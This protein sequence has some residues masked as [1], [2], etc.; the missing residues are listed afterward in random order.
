M[1]INRGWIAAILLGISCFLLPAAR[2]D[3]ASDKP[4]PLTLTRQGDFLISPIITETQSFNTTILE[5]GA[6]FEGLEVNTDPGNEAVWRTEGVD[7]DGFGADALIFHAP[8]TRIQFKKRAAPEEKILTGKLWL[9]PYLAEEFER[10]KERARLENL[11]AGPAVALT[12]AGPAY[13]VIK[14]EEWGADESLRFWTPS[15]DDIQKSGQDEKAED[16][17][18]DFTTKY[19]DEIGVKLQIGIDPV[20]NLLRWPLSYSKT[21]RKI[22]VHHTDSDLHDLNGDLQMDSRDMKAYVRAIYRF[23]AITKGWGDIGYNYLIDPFG[24]IYEG[25]AGGE[26]VIG[27]HVLCHNNGTIGIAIIGNYQENEVPQPALDALT[28]LVA[29]KA[30]LY[31]LD[32]EAISSFR[33]KALPNVVGHRDLR[34]TACPGNYLYGLLASIRKRASLLM[35][36]GEFSDEALAAATLDY[37]AEL[38]SDLNV[39]NLHPSRHA[40]LELKFKNNGKKIWDRSTWLHVALNNQKNIEVVP[41]LQDKRYVAADMKENEVPPGSIGTFEVEFAAGYV[42][43]FYTFELSPIING[44]YKISRAAIVVPLMVDKPDFNY[45]IYSS[46]LPSGNVFQGEKMEAAI[47]LL[48]TGN[49]IWRNYGKNSI[50]LGTDHSRDHKSVFIKE[51][52]ARLAYLKQSDVQPGTRG[53]FVFTL[54]IPKNRVGPVHEYFT[55]VIEGVQWLEDKKLDFEVTIKKP[56]HLAK[57]VKKTDISEMMPGESRKVE[58]EIE[59]QGDLRWTDEVM[60]MDLRSQGIKLFQKKITPID[61][62]AP[63]QKATYGFWI[64]A[65][66]QGGNYTVSI[67]SRFNGL[68]IKNGAARFTVR[69]PKMSLRAKIEKIGDRNLTLAP[70]KEY[71]LSV[72]F[73]NIGNVVW[74]N[75]GDSPIYLAPSHP[76]DRLSRL[77]Y[78]SGWQNK[79]R[80]AKLKESVVLP[81]EVGTFQFKIK[82]PQGMYHE[83][84]QLIIENVG[85]IDGSN[86]RWDLRAFDTKTKTANAS[87]SEPPSG[88]LFGLPSVP[89]RIKLSFDTRTADIIVHGDY[90]VEDG[91]GKLLFKAPKES[92]VEVELGVGIVN[93]HG[94]LITKSAKIIRFIPETSEGIFEILS[95]ERR[96]SWNL[97]LNDNQ[98]RRILELR[99]IDDKPV[100]INELPLENY[101]RGVAEVSD[102]LPFEKLKTIAVLARSYAEFY[103]DPAHR[104][105]LGMPYDGSDDPDIFQKYLGYGYEQRSKNFTTAVVNTKSEVVTYKGS[106]IKTPY[107]N[108]SDGRTRSAEEVWGWK[109]TPYLKAVDDPWCD[110]KTLKG[111]GVGLSG[112]GAT[113]LAKQGKTYQ[114]IIKYYYTGVE[115]EKNRPPNQIN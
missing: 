70:N 44:R 78:E 31:K 39:I 106:L 52:K 15:E 45:E 49:T 37:N 97:A 57:I 36:S 20:G 55:P 66:Y 16:S 80:A 105:F 69:V 26:G 88:P 98:F 101:L 109:D 96:P 9:L 40:T 112:C 99:L 58:F 11:V 4:I 38:V 83:Y 19:Q 95:W 12:E 93:V 2:A 79:Y 48:N 64:Q 89:I 13:R 3:S 86:I 115:I 110:D 46:S 59:N 77:Y 102:S 84:F 100:Y 75:K 104:K 33:G 71:T 67:Q 114:E 76:Q 94:G 1:K 18:G 82:P 92:T 21:I 72:Q 32:P 65:P 27:A 60:E 7:D 14:R 81:G 17:C 34:P 68:A 56:L 103:L 74:R 91:E 47:E 24:N 50:T 6:P 111:H 30:K 63:K 25:R 8:T 54:D 23:H 22:V 29:Q 108:Q 35:R 113:E 90:R 62:L 53:K 28:Y 73:K 42:S 87:P 51:N 41:L 85:W 10:D 107:F 43:G 5:F 61:P